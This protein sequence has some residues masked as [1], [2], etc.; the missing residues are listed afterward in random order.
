[1]GRM[2]TGDANAE[3]LSVVRR[4]TAAWREGPPSEIVARITPCF[5][6]NAVICGGPNLQAVARGADT[7]AASYEQFV[8][9]ATVHELTAPDPEIHVAGDAATALCPWKMTYTLNNETYTESGHDLLVCT[10]R[11]GD[12][13]VMWRA[14]LPAAS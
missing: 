4:I 3:I 13:R 1:M 11:D 5:D 6:A 14:M 2:T 9:M 12:W 10:R 8:R 7:C